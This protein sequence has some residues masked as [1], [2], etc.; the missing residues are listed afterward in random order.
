MSGVWAPQDVWERIANFIRNTSAQ[1][2]FASTCLSALSAMNRSLTTSHIK[3]SQ[4]FKLCA[5]TLP[6]TLMDNILMVH[7]IPPDGTGLVLFIDDSESGDG[8]QLAWLARG[9]MRR[10]PLGLDTVPASAVSNIRFSPD[11]GSIALLVTLA[12]GSMVDPEADPLRRLRGWNSTRMEGDKVFDIEY[13]PCEDCTV[14]VVDLCED[15]KGY[16]SNMVIHTFSHVFVP[17]YG[18][19]MVWRRYGPTALHQE[20][21]FAAML[22]SEAGAATYLVRW[23][24]FRNSSSS[25]FI[26]MACIEG[27]SLEFLHDKRSAMITHP[28]T[29]CTSRIE[30]ANDAKHIFFDTVSKFGILRFDQVDDASA[31]QVTRAD[32]QNKSVIRQCRLV[33]STRNHNSSHEPSHCPLDEERPDNVANFDT[34]S[35]P[36]QDQ[37]LQNCFN[38]YLRL[39]RMSPDGTLLCSVISVS[40][41]N[42][43]KEDCEDFPSS[44]HIEMRS[45]LTGQLIYR[46]VLIRKPDPLAPRTKLRVQLEKA[47][48]LAQHTLAFSE[49]SS[50]LVVWDTHLTKSKC[51]IVQ[52]LPA[53]LDAETGSLIQ[54]FGTIS[55]E[56]IL[57]SIQTAPDA[58]TV[59][60]TRMDESTIK[61]DAIDAG[62]GSVIKSVTLAD[63]VHQPKQF[64]AHSIYLLP[65]RRLHTVSRGNLDVLWD[66]TRGSLGCG[67]TSFPQHESSEEE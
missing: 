39:S 3:L 4:N 61:M 7:V 13:D 20:L 59:Y 53:I 5:F 66:T 2:S 54:D 19:D 16:P 55:E 35:T 1:K 12:H 29:I 23:K 10:V 38:D 65:H 42:T 36:N 26:F 63:G 51:V 34:S 17:E 48:D 45:S 47:S 58:R 31:A 67:W 62:S 52:R 41:R 25:N 28:D 49:D 18:F 24:N 11:G 6:E 21:A 32:L 14:Q 30:I 15:E 22:H 9:R 33:H 43:N 40:Q 56:S 64:S 46:R 60:A 8:V 44:K 37:S 57:E 50:L 27:A